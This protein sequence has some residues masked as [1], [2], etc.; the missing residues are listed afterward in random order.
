MPFKK[1]DPKGIDQSVDANRIFVGRA[2]ELLFFRQDILEP[3]N[4]KHNIISIFGQG[5][6]GKST[7][8][9]RLIEETYA[10]DFKDYSLTALVNERQTNPIS[11]MERFA[12]QF[13]EA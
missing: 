12:D 6:V 10:R 4:P 9:K 11:V 5:G 2:S 8:V 1:T 13:N 7:L 3:E